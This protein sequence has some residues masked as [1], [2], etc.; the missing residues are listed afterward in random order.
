VDALKSSRK[1]ERDETAAVAAE[2]AGN[3]RKEMKRARVMIPTGTYVCVCT[4]VRVY[5]CIYTY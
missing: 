2:D 3:K 4:Y 5:T 1:R